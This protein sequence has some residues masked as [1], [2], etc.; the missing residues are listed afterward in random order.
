M[1]HAEKDL[2]S[3][4]VKIKQ[5]LTITLEKS[6]DSNYSIYVQK[7][8]KGGIF[9]TNI[10]AIVNTLTDEVMGYEIDKSNLSCIVSNLDEIK[11]YLKNNAKVLLAYIK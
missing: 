3:F 2:I 11:E 5:K 1:A 9:V 10:Y 6:S 8:N 7:D 4:E